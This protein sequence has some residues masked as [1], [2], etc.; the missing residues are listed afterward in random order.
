MKMPQTAFILLGLALL[1][2]AC[3]SNNYVCPEATGTPEPPLELEAL[4]ALAVTPGP[5][6]TP[7][8]VEIRGKTVLVD[9]VVSGP[10]CNDHWS[11][12]VYVGCDLQ[13]PRWQG[14]GE[15]E[16]EALFFKDCDLR[17]APDT[18]VYVEAHGNQPYLQGCSCHTRQ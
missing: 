13:I 4:I 14:E 18:V 16:S 3:Q 5:A 12:V 10:V 6:P 8:T 15:E 9:R 2:G 17:I 11:G 1:V 7:T